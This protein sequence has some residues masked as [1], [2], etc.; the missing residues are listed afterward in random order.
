MLL[1]PI[2]RSAPGAQGVVDLYL[3]PAYDDIA[4]LFFDG[5]RWQIHYAQPHEAAKGKSPMA[6]PR[7]L[8]KTSL[9]N[10]LDE[11]TSH[12]R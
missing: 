1:E 5:E 8:S 2:A 12:A 9:R 4:S 7:T 11:L 3:M 10:A 6:G